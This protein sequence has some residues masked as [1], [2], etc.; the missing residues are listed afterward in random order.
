METTKPFRA[1][2]R[3]LVVENDYVT[4]GGKPNWS[5]FASELHGV[6]YETLRQA[7]TGRRRPTPRLM[8]ECARALRVRPEHF[9]EYRVYLAQRDFDPDAVGE[10]RA[11]ENLA[12]WQRA[13]LPD[14]TSNPYSQKARK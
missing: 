5:A 9:L 6:H 14:T 2:L 11:L 4:Q 13:R 3:D 8:E 1:A 10:Q 7:A 12:R